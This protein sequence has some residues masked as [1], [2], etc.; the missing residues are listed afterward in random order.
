MKDL[1]RLIDN[2]MKK[3][4][5]VGMAIV[6]G[7]VGGR[8]G[9]IHW[10]DCVQIQILKAASSC[11]LTLG[12]WEPGGHWKMVLSIFIFAFPFL[13]AFVIHLCNLHKPQPL[14]PWHL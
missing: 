4:G 6:G 11:S 10:T 14:I 1:E 12:I 5:L 2:A 7:I 8:P 3:D 13:T 9:W